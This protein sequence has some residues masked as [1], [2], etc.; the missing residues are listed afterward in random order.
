MSL[1]PKCFGPLNL[2]H[3][4]PET[5]QFFDMFVDLLCLQFDFV[6]FLLSSISGQIVDEEMS[7]T[8]ATTVIIVR[9]NIFY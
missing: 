4:E 3:T 9:L 5:L 7:H 2:L 6:L 8:S 1:N